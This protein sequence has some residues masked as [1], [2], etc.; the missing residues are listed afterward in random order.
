VQPEIARFARVVAYD[1]RGWAGVRTA[2][3]RTT[4][5][6]SCN[7]CTRRFSRQA[8]RRLRLRWTLSWR[9]VRPRLCAEY[10][11]E[12]AGMIFVDATTPGQFAQIPSLKRGQKTLG[13]DAACGRDARLDRSTAAR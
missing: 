1:G 7:N 4:P 5:D 3:S 11:D 6:I 13:D 8:S 9:A 2:A 12:V 10:P